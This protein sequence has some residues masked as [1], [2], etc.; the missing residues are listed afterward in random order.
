MAIFNKQQG[1]RLAEDQKAW[2][3]R[4]VVERT[5]NKANNATCMNVATLYEGGLGVLPQ[6]ILKEPT[7]KP[8][9]LRL[10]GPPRVGRG[11]VGGVI[12]F[13]HQICTDLNNGPVELQKAWKPE[14]P[15]KGWPLFNTTWEKQPIAYSASD[16]H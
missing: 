8:R 1:V 13:S 16:A 3:A 9:I 10:L 12:G 5:Q 7:L 6:K 15:E 14:K 11:G 2:K 4:R